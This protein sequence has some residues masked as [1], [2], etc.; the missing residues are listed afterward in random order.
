[1]SYVTFGHFGDK[2]VDEVI[3]AANKQKIAG[4]VAHAIISPISFA[5]KKGA[6][7]V[8]GENGESVSD[9]QY[10]KAIILKVMRDNN[11]MPDSK[12]KTKLRGMIK[13]ILREEDVVTVHPHWTTPTYKKNGYKN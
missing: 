12:F 2:P 13:E 4:E 10:V 7:V 3:K 6:R 5:V 11:M 8:A 1:M 9:E